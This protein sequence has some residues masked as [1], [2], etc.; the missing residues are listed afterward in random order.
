MLISVPPPSGERRLVAFLKRCG[1]RALASLCLLCMAFI[2]CKPGNVE[3]LMPWPSAWCHCWHWNPTMA[4]RGLCHAAMPL[5]PRP[6]QPAAD[7]RSTSGS[8]SLSP[9]PPGADRRAS[10]SWPPS[11]DAHNR[12]TDGP[13]LLILTRPHTR[14]ANIPAWATTLLDCSVR[15][16]ISSGTTSS[17]PSHHPSL[18]SPFSLAIA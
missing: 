12:S 17:L 16:S 2:R 9:I 15:R 10:R 13:P 4:E 5:S 7:C 3:S 11:P 14:L 8:P 18:S 6:K 1:Q